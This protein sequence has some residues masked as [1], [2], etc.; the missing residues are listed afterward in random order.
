M[1]SA[2]RIWPG[3][4]QALGRAAGRL[5]VERV[6][7]DVC[8]IEPGGQRL[9]PQRQ[10]DRRRHGRR[11]ASAG[12]RMWRR[13]AR[14]RRSGPSGSRADTAASAATTA[15]RP[16]HMFHL[17]RDSR[18][19]ASPPAAGRPPRA[20]A[21]ARAPR[22][23][24]RRPTGPAA[25]TSS[26]SPSYSPASVAGSAPPA[27]RSARS[28]CAAASRCDASRAARRAAAGRVPQYRRAVACRLRV[29]GHPG[30]IVAPEGAQR[31][32]HQPVNRLAP[33]RR[34]PPAPPPAWRS[35]DGT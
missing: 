17:M 21:P 7:V 1:S 3:P 35:R 12:W 11:T 8:G 19:S 28:Y 22:R 33:V 32:Q 26:A 34:R 4:V 16:R 18:R 2:R 15:S 13:P 25:P 31:G 20:T 27:N 6:A 30:V 24:R 10:V 5:G 23:S 14:V 29:E 9:G